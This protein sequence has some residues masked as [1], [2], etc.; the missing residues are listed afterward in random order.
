MNSSE[1]KT[2]LE[3]HRKWIETKGI[4]GKNADLSGC[5]LSD[6]KLRGCD[7]SGCDLSDS[8]LSR[9]DLSGCD[10]RG[11]DLSDSNLSRCDLSGCDLRGCDLRGCD[12]SDSNLSRCD[13][14]D[15]NLSGCDL[16]GCDLD[17]SSLPLWC[18]SLDIKVDKRI[19][20]QIAYHFC[21]MVCDNPEVKQAQNA[22]M[23]L[24]NQFHRAAEC[25]KIKAKS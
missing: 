3:C 24:A 13:L 2:I 25:G 9:C 14:S 10:L 23:E 15:S 6:S 20:A 21:R 19:A 5:D 1:L 8:N 16:S 11:C 12:L 4:E 22:I 17:Y 7:L 18:G